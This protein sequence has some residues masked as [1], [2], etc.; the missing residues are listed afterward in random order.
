M[1]DMKSEPKLVVIRTNGYYPAS[2]LT[3]R[4]QGRIYSTFITKNRMAVIRLTKLARKTEFGGHLAL[5]DFLRLLT[6][7]Y[8]D[9]A[10]KPQEMHIE[11][12]EAGY[13]EVSQRDFDGLR[14]AALNEIFNFNTVPSATTRFLKY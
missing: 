2:S 8:R 14:A 4:A 12:S 9:G 3:G 13:K 6:I 1:Y 7:S 5:V 10:N 11:V